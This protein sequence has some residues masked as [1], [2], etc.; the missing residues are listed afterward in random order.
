M[1]RILQSWDALILVFQDA[2]LSENL[3]SVEITL[4]NLRNPVYKLYFSFLSYVLD[5]VNKMNLEFQSEKI[6]IHLVLSRI[7]GLYRT[8]LRNFI[9]K[10]VLDKESLDKIN[11]KDARIYTG[12][13]TVYFG[14]QVELILTNSDIKIPKS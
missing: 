1:N 3:H 4:D 8:I 2:V 12:I 13:D 5:L 9:K 11:P 14:A 7:G 6:K 10:D